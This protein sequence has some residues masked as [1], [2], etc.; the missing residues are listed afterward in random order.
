MRILDNVVAIALGV[1]LL[2]STWL[3]ITRIG[4]TT[5]GDRDHRQ[6][7]NLLHCVEYCLIE[8]LIGNGA[9]PE[10]GFEGVVDNWLANH[11]E[12]ARM[13]ELA[14]MWHQRRDAWGTP[15]HLE[16]VIESVDQEKVKLTSCGPD[17]QLHT[18]DDLSVTLF[19]PS[20]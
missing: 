18:D 12:R 16:T 6:T 4:R 15:L 20:Q 3:V 1:F 11:P 19:L 13:S 14:S 2:G 17:Q 10:S 5:T 8:H 9:I 7:K